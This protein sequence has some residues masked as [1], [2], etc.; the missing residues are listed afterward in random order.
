MEKQ[1]KASEEADLAIEPGA[2]SDQLVEAVVEEVIVPA[3]VQAT[4]KAEV[5]PAKREA[6]AE[7]PAAERRRKV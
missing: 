6:H 1:S 7:R 5:A 3:I 2:L 4:P